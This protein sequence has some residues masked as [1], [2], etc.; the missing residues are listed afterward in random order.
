VGKRRTTSRRVLVS[1]FV[2]H[3]PRL[4]TTLDAIS[5]G[6][7]NLGLGMGARPYV[8]RRTRCSSG[9]RH[10]QTASRRASTR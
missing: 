6:R 10:S 4:T 2:L 1:N 8:V 5:N 7:L 9:D 3:P